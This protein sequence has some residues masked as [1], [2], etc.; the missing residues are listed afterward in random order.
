[1]SGEQLWEQ[2]LNINEYSRFLRRA[3]GA[4]ILANPSGGINQR[5]GRL[6]A[7]RRGI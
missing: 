3:S 7:R 5:L 1:M 2:L 4:K 6:P